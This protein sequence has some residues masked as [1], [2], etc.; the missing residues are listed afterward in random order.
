MSSTLFQTPQFLDRVYLDNSIQQ[1]LIG[2]GATVVALFVLSIARRQIASRVGTYLAKKSQS[3]AAFVG[4][5]LQRTSWWLVLVLSVWFGASLL[6][7]APTVSRLIQGAVVLVVSLQAL[8]WAMEAV[9]FG[10]QTFLQR[11]RDQH[12]ADDPALATAAPAIRF[13]GRLVVIVVIALLA[14]QNLGVDVTA[15]IAGLGVGGIAIALAVQNILGD[16]FASLSIVLDKPFVVGDFIVVG[17]RAG[18]VEKIGLKTTRVRSLSGE[19]LIFANSDLLGSRIQN[20]KRMR[21]RRIVF[22]L[23]VTYQTPM[24]TVAKLAAVIK[25]C[26]TAQPKARFDRSHFKSFG[27]SSLD[28]ESVYW[29]LDADYGVYM[30]TQQA[31]NLAIGRRFQEMGVDFAYPTQTVFLAREPGAGTEPGKA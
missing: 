11:R 25:D 17:D 24:D 8:S 6:T 22:T 9:E 12:G 27:A 3:G 2:I 16:L 30:D 5:L 26:I 4:R 29:V 20:F 1:W 10:V 31:I 21:E 7:L 18:T 19:Q 14:L 15:M 28:F 13:L 23:G